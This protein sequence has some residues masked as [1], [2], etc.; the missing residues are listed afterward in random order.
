MAVEQGWRCSSR[1]IKVILSHSSCSQ[2][3]YR[4]LPQP[5]SITSCYSRG[6]LVE[7]WYLDTRFLKHWESEGLSML[8]HLTPCYNYLSLLAAATALESVRWGGGSY[9]LPSSYISISQKLLQQLA[10]ISIFPGSLCFPLLQ[11]GITDTVLSCLPACLLW[12]RHN[13]ENSKATQNLSLQD[14]SL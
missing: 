10:I 9:L 14:Y 1:Y 13:I 2:D 11:T 7:S 8:F 3:P 6:Q 12:L 5:G 4:L